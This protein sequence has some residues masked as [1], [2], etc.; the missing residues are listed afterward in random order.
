MTSDDEHGADENP[1]VTR[2]RKEKKELR[3]KNLSFSAKI[4]AM[5]KA[6]K[7]G[8]KQKAKEVNAE[9]EKLE[10]EL[11]ER[12]R[13]ESSSQAPPTEATPT[14]S[15]EKEGAEPEEEE[16]EEGGASKFYKN[17]KISSKNAK[18]QAKKKEQEERLK[19]AQAADKEASKSKDSEKHLEKA[20]IKQMLQ[21]ESLRMIDIP[22][23]GDCLYAS[24]SHQ[25]QEEGI[26]ISVRKLRKSCAQYMRDNKEEFAPFIS[27]ADVGGV[28]AGA[29]KAAEWETYLQGVE[30]CADVGGVWGGELELKAA[31]LIYEKTIVVYRV[32]G[33]TY[34]IGEQ[35]SS[36]RDRP[37]RLV[38]LRHAYHL[39]EHYNSTCYY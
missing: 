23:D 16:E 19:A 31:S 27:D 26:E 39:G 22:A 30:K 29:D 21:E 15:T 20:A 3:A 37:L 28:S 2:H 4:T 6:A 18:K 10:K 25:L 11:E 17:F 1:M 5:K 14:P 32:A 8:N 7:S 12:H 24:I 35:F 38:Y 9:C 36:P 34:K 13:Q 33:G